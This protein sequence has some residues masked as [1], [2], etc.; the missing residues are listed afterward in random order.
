MDDITAIKN[1]IHFLKKEHELEITLHPWG[2]EQLITF[3][4]LI[5]FN[6]HENSHCIYVKSFSGAHYHC[7]MRQKKIMDKCKNGSFCGSCYA[8]VF[9]YIYPIFDG[10]S[11][12]GFICVSG[13][14]TSD[15][16]SYVKKC[17]EDYCIPCENLIQ[18]SLSLKEDIPEKHFIDT[19]ITPLQKM[20]EL[21][22]S[23]QN[24]KKADNTLIDKVLRYINCNYTKDIDIDEIC[25]VFSCSRSRVSHSFKQVTGQSFRE[26]IT[27]LRLKTAKSLL[28]HS[29]LNITEIALAIGFNDSN[30]FS[31]VF[32]AS[33]GVSP[34]IYRS[35]KAKS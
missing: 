13:Y 10:S 14:R 3:S 11:V 28:R 31:N 8:G 5:L 34:R 1:Y 33:I 6:I 17:S 24:H 32:K 15:C 9:E 2:D 23:G 30:Y 18:T 22:Y 27:S 19:V 26:Y 7:I 25:K 35:Q 29:N 4:E 20:L 21:A 16:A 12:T